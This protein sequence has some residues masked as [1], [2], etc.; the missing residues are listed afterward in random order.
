MIITTTEE[1][2]RPTEWL[3]RLAE[4]RALYRQLLEHAGSLAVAA[5]R[6][7]RARCRI[8]PVP[9]LVPTVAELRVAAN[10][11]CR[12]VGVRTTF[13]AGQLVSDCAEV[14]LTVIVPINASAA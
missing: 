8:Q 4:N 14:G 2:E 9:N 3:R 11:I 13:H 1:M 6:L 7:A 10:E 12:Y 5:Y